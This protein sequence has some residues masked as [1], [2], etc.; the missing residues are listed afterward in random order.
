VAYAENLAQG[1]FSIFDQMYQF[2]L[3]RMPWHTDWRWDYTWEPAYY[4][5]YH[6]SIA[7]K[8]VPYDVK[9]PWELSRF[10]FLL[11]LAQMTAIDPAAHWQKT[12][13]EL[14]VQWER[15]NPLAHSV[16]WQP[17][18]CAMHGISLALAAQMLAADNATQPSALAP[19]LRQLT[20]QG[21]FLYRTVE[22]TKI[23]GNHYASNLAGLLLMGSTLQG[24][25]PPAAQWMA[26]A[27]KRVCQEIQ[28]QYYEDGVHFEKA[29]SYHRLVT[30][31]FLLSLLVIEQT[32][33]AVPEEAQERIRSAC[34]YTRCYTR[35]DGLSANFGDNDG[36][37][38]LALDPCALRDH[39]SL[40]ALSAAYFKEPVHKA[41]AEHPSAAIPWL[42]GSRGVQRWNELPACGE[43]RLISHHFDQGG[44]IVSQSDG[45]YLIADYGEVGKC[46]RGA[47]GHNDTFSFELSLDGNPVIIDS[48]SPIYTGDLSVMADYSSTGRH[49]TAMVDDREM[50]RLLGIWRISD[51]AR[52]V[53]VSFTGEPDIDIAQGE[54]RGYTRLADPVIHQRRLAFDRNMG[55]LACRDTFRCS[56]RH[57][58]K[59]FLHFAP[60]I[61][62]A[63]FADKAVASL[64]PCVP[65]VVRWT[66]GAQALV[67]ACQVSEVFG[68]LTNSLRLVLEYEI[69]GDTT[70]SFEIKQEAVKRKRSI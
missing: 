28:L 45:N 33:E 14:V 20:L 1:R 23:R 64:G 36:A 17:M 24:L 60:G 63:L 42:L 52:P 18:I 6:F 22:Y 37:W 19:L 13:A 56:D 35:P 2:D 65:V 4:Q 39:R 30:E 38:L 29:T 43:H 50:A 8:E 40:L 27:R 32:G 41:A 59:Q 16:N 51:E 53:A 44:M 15:E 49:N 69:Q 58:V 26:Y 31:F 57:R 7:D 11:P 61:T 67:E 70:L 66:T 21:E 47:H 62:I 48:G 68:Q 34:E 3:D 54:H 10:A 46:G 5:S 25:Y 9:F 55:R 12:I